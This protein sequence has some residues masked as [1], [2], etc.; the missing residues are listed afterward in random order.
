MHA[1]H[2]KR[3][4]HGISEF[5]RDGAHDRRDS[6]RRDDARRRMEPA[7]DD[8]HDEYQLAAGG[9]AS[10]PGAVDCRDRSR[11]SHA[12]ESLVVD[13][14]QALQLSV[15]LRDWMGDQGRQARADGE[16]SV[17]F[18]DHDGV[19]EFA[20]CDLLARRVDAVG[21]SELRQ[22]PAAAGNG[23][24]TW[25][26]AG[27]IPWDQSGVGVQERTDFT[28]EKQRHGELPERG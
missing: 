20:G 2:H 5:A 25:G 19:L 18:G 24:R 6:I 27:A 23:N 26:G 14:R 16:E 11:H 17:V 15:R 21:N 28:T 7:A 10:Q 8:P 9:K 22:G 13:R 4:V 3:T 1:H 12:D